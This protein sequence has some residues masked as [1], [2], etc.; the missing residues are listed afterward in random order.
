MTMRTYRHFSCPNDHQ[1]V[2]KTSENDQPYSK[3]WDSTTITGMIEHG[4]DP[5]GYSIYICE[6]C[7]LTM[8]FDKNP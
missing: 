4:K 6:V 3:G 7:R 5:L 8:V 1:G 2:E